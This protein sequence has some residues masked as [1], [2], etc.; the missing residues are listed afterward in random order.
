MAHSLCSVATC[1]CLP[2]NH[3]T[4]CPDELPRHF[5]LIAQVYEALF[6]GRLSYPYMTS[7]QPSLSH[8]F[9]KLFRALTAFWNDLVYLLALM[10]IVFFCLGYQL[11]KALDRH[12]INICWM[13]WINDRKVREK[14][15]CMCTD[16]CVR[17][18]IC[19]CFGLFH[20]RVWCGLQETPDL[21]T[22]NEFLTWLVLKPF[23]LCSYLFSCSKGHRFHF[24]VLSD[25]DI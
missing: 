11:H 18:C 10:L 21:E 5:P 4:V 9:I 3:Y 22:R 19:L 25:T 7:S 13:N 2:T 15:V 1:S 8:V 14:S 23:S 17:A 24:L 16:V 20:K 12:S 6:L